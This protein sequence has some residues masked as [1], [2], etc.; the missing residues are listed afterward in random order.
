[1]ANAMLEILDG[2]CF[3]MSPDVPAFKV[4]VFRRDFKF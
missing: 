3:G 4:R 1:M 2:F